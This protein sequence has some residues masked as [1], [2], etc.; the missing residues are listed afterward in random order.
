[1]RQVTALLCVLILPSVPSVPSVPTR[2]ARPAL[3]ARPARPAHFAQ[4][5]VPF[6]ST[7][8][9]LVVLPV[10][11]TE[12]GDRYV[13]DLSQDQFVV[14]DNGRRVPIDLFSNEDTPV[15]VGLVIDASGSMRKKLSEV[16]AA[17]MA[18]AVKSN[19]NDELFAVWFN[20]DVH[21]ALPGQM[22]LPASDHTGLSRLLTTLVP[23]G[24]TSLYDGL[25]A[26]LDH[27]SNGSRARKVLVVVSDGGDNA[28]EATLD[29]VLARAR[30]SS[31]V[32]YTIGL[33]DDL[34]PDR[35]PGVLKA[36]SS[37][38]GG[39]RFLPDAASPLM[40]ACEHIAREIRSGYTIGYVPPDRDG[41]FHHVRVEVVT[42]AKRKLNVRTRPG[43]FASRAASSQP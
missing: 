34:D 24:R 33:F 32:I 41:A 5:Q 27:L 6:R 8:S 1:M 42:P 9:E 31:A 21:R 12:R 28:S 10:I 37:A 39:E 25:I 2:P 3:P 17:A 23:E 22:F 26:A 29:R 19:P 40:K 18:F 20:D 13:S 35:N 30:S 11:V 7:A 4:E 38:T 14:Y 15:T 36:L 16:V 43:Y